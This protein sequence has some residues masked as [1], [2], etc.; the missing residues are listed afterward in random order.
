MKSGNISKRIAYDEWLNWLNTRFPGSKSKILTQ[1]ANKRRLGATDDEPDDKEWY[2]QIIDAASV[3][4]P[5]YFNYSLQKRLIDVQ[6]ERARQ[7]QAPLDERYFKSSSNLGPT[8]KHQIDTGIS[9]DTKNI[10]VFG[11]LGLAAF[12]L[13]SNA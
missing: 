5:G 9:D 8:I 1:V 11:G 13:L 3:I 4:V 12:Y 10:L 6:L 2:E 7:G